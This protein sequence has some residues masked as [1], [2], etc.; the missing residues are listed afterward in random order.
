[1]QEPPKGMLIVDS[2][3][4]SLRDIDHIAV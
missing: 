4:D 1:V 3:W 2:Q